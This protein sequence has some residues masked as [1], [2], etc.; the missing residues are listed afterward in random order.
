[1]MHVTAANPQPTKTST[2]YGFSTIPSSPKIGRLRF[3]YRWGRFGLKS[4][5]RG[6]WDFVGNAL[7]TELVTLNLAIRDT[8]SR[9]SAVECNIC[10]WRGHTFYPNVGS[11]Y[12]E[13]NTA[14]PGCHCQDRH[15]SLVELLAIS[16]KLFDGKHKVVEVAP[17]RNLQRFFLLQGCHYLSFDLERF[18]MEK[19]DITAMRF[20]N[21]SIDYFLALHVLEHIPAEQRALEEILRVLRPGGTAILQVPVFLDVAETYE[22][23]RPDPRETG[24][25]RRYGRDLAKRLTESGFEV[26]EIGVE[27]CFPEE[28]ISRYRMG[29]APFYLCRKPYAQL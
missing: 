12:H 19:G 13:R 10:G 2:V 5:L 4:L 24:H 3:M 8:V 16:T 9:G 18:A 27:D 21:D 23:E 22:Y 17:M 1:M 11:G 20:E 14:C 6:D 26:T 25:V 7:Q 28:I 15:R 29:R